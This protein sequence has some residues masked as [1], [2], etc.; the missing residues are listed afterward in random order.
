MSKRRIGQVH[1]YRVKKAKAGGRKA[2]LLFMLLPAVVL[3]FLFN[4][5]PIYGIVIAF[6]DFSPFQGIFKSP[7]VG[8]KY[9]HAFLT[10]S[11]FW[12]VMKN[13]LII[14]FYDV[15]FGFTAPILFA[16]LLN[17]MMNRHAKKIIQ[18]IS[19]LPHFLSWV[20]VAGIFYQ[21]LSPGQ[22]GIINGYL[23]KFFGIQPVYFMAEEK[24]FVAITVFAEIWKSVGWSAILYF[25]TL[26]GI[27]PTLYEVS[28]ID[29]ASRPRQILHITLPAL[30]PVISLMLVLKISTIF[31]IG[32]ERLFVLQNSLVLSVSEVISTYVYRSGLLKSQFSFTTAIGLTQSG[33]GFLLLL[34][35]NKV[36]RRLTGTGLY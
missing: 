34:G 31:T 24:Y 22:S 15:I 27:D 8:F 12:T 20:I 26:A 36:S 4:Y 14:N 13:T 19:Y 18:T 28:H 3:V 30:A 35:C 16:L 5:I 25:A 9:F 17:E 21:M 23:V 6:K 2:S 33:L 10:D 29:G 1:T 32:F 11:T 7:W